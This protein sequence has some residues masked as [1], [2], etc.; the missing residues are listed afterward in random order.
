MKDRL[1]EY[2]CFHCLLQHTANTDDKETSKVDMNLFVTINIA[3]NYSLTVSTAAEFLH[4]AP[5]L[6]HRHVEPD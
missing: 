2:V 1:R 3:F 4:S 6:H 5:P